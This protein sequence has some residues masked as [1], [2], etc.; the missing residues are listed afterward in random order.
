MTEPSENVGKIGGDGDAEIN[1]YDELGP[2]YPFNI[3]RE[4]RSSR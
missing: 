1:R 4:Q 3:R 2:G